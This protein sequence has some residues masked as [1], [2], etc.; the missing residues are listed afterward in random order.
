MKANYVTKTEGRIE[1]KSLWNSLLEILPLL[2]CSLKYLE[3][4]KVKLFFRQ[5]IYFL[6]PYRSLPI[7]SIQD[8]PRFVNSGVVDLRSHIFKNCN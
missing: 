8:Q 2:Q 6:L 7:F 4:L 5:P 1:P 3:D